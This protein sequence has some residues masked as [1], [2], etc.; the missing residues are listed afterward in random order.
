MF[1]IA[2]AQLHE[3][4]GIVDERAMGTGKAVRGIRHF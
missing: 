4:T 3:R 1:Q 2:G